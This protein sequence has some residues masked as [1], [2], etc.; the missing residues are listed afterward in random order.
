MDHRVP[1]E[2]KMQL[3]Q[4]IRAENHGN[5][6]KIRQRERIL[7]GT[8]TQPPLFDKGWFP[9]AA[10]PYE[11][12]PSQPQQDE[13]MLVFPPSTFRYRMILA[14]LLFAGFLLCDTGDGRI[15]TYTTNE[16]HAMITADTF[17]LYDGDGNETMEGLA[18][19]LD[20]DK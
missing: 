1:L 11:N 8:D 7:Y 19:L 20:F 13:A 6:M 10:S 15:G 2:K 12:N 3:A 17:H 5:R 9:D 18:S 16:V 4:Y 14:V